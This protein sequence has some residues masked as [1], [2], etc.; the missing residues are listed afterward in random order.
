M[1]KMSLMWTTKKSHIDPTHQPKL[2]L[3]A[4]AT[5]PMSNVHPVRIWLM[6]EYDS[7]TQMNSYNLLINKMTEPRDVFLF[8]ISINL[9]FLHTRSLLSPSRVPSPRIFGSEFGSEFSRRVGLLR[10]FRSHKTNE[11][12]S[13]LSSQWRRSRFSVSLAWSSGQS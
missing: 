11:R 1:P 13:P 5:K 2:R 6:L 7:Q 3:P 12:H 8:I 4:I 10:D 9:I